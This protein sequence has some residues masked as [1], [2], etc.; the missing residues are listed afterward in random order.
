MSRATFVIGSVVFVV[1][2]LDIRKIVVILQKIHMLNL[3]F[4]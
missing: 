3:L 4:L 2:I 1:F